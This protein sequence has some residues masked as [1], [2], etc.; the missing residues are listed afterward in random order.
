MY[1]KNTSNFNVT[2]GMNGNRIQSLHSRFTTKFITIAPVILRGLIPK[3]A[4]NCFCLL[5]EM[6]HLVFSERMRIEGW[7]PEH[8]D[9]FKKLLWKHA[10][11]FEELYGLSSCTE[12]LEYSLQMPE[13]IVKFS[14]LDNYWCYVFERLVH[15][16]KL[17]T[18]NKSMCKT[19]ADR[20][21]QLLF[22]TLYLETKE[23]L[24]DTSRETASTTIT[25]QLFLHSSTYSGAIALK[26][27]M[28]NNSD[29]L[30]QNTHAQLYDGIMIGKESILLLD[31]QQ[32][33]DIDYWIQT[34][35]SPSG[36]PHG[37][38]A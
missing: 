5:S 25:P 17:Q 37:G 34:H 26:E 14:T 6:H 15:Y 38:H 29:P 3:Q 9:Y 30:T 23:Q 7:Q 10:I 32:V 4:Y 24:S 31:T 33:T 2:R 13:D 11:M 20:A 22:V 19:F 8:L 21:N 1:S 28:T 16:Y 12:N 36:I 35:N 27:Y 18:T